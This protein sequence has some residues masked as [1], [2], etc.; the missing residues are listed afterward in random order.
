MKIHR[1]YNCVILDVISQKAL[2][3][4]VDM[5]RGEIISTQKAAEP[6]PDWVIPIRH[7]QGLTDTCTGQE[8]AIKE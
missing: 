3:V 6:G 5:I 1:R 4:Q 7:R 8:Y 2:S